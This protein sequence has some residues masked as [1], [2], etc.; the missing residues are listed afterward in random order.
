MEEKGHSKLSSEVQ[1]RHLI[2]KEA[3]NLQAAAAQKL[4]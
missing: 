3:E 1:A 2:K 4:N